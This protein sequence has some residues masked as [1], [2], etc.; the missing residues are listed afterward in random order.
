MSGRLNA[1]TTTVIDT[2]DAIVIKGGSTTINV[3]SFVEDGSGAAASW[4]KG[5]RTLVE[6]DIDANL[7]NSRAERALN[8]AMQA[9]SHRLKL[10]AFEATV[11]ARKASAS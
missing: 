4:M 2:A 11:A 8:R 1:F 7:D 9:E 5:K 6:E 3:L 10:E